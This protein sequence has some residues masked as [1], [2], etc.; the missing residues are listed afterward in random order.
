MKRIVYGKY[1][2]RWDVNEQVY[3]KLQKNIEMN[4][5]ITHTV[6]LVIHRINIL[7]LL[8]TQ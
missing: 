3:S 2:R 7:L 1:L 4:N 8:S 5:V 6:I